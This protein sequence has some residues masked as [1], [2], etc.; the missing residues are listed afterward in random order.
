MER[1]LFLFFALDNGLIDNSKL[2]TDRILSQLKLRQCTED[3]SKIYDDIKL[4]FKSLDQGSKVL[5][6]EGFNGELFSGVLPPKIHFLDLQPKSFF[7]E[8]IMNSKLSKELKLHGDSAEI[9]KEFGKDV[10]PI[11][12][13][14]L[15]MDSR[16]FNSELNVTILGH[17]L[18]QSLDD[19]GSYLKTGQ[20]KRKIDGVLLYSTHLN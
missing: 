20:M 2:F 9:W 13:N 6:I 11:I 4:L 12:R 7:A 10:N 14:L 1:I 16:D 3:S 15:I 5:G 18:E 17:I 19:L 8:C